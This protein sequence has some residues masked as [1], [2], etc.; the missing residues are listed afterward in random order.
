MAQQKYQR[1]GKIVDVKKLASRR[2]AAPN[3]DFSRSG[4]LRSMR[5]GDQRRNDM[6]RGQIEIVG[7]AIEIGRH[8][9][10]EIAAVL[11][12]VRAAQ[13]DAG[14]LSD[15]V[16]LVG[17]LERTGEQGILA[18]RL[19]CE[20]RIDAGRAEKQ[21]LFDPDLA[22]R[23][24][25]VGF[26]H[27][28]VVKEIGGPCIVGDN[29]ADGRRGNDHHLRIFLMH[30]ALDCILAAQVEGFPSN[31]DDFAILAAQPAHNG[32]ADHAAMSRNPDAAA[33][34]IEY[35]PLTVHA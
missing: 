3:L 14:D 28:I 24:D 31:R 32:A 13:H 1:I 17:R 9:R 22:C 27:Q 25:D 35:R 30:P 12:A 15:G 34:Q 4:Q 19:S 16:P 2:A 11:P 20:P 29:A 21:E 26:D 23:L 8:R 10:D 5:L 18:H 33:S 7:K 6:G